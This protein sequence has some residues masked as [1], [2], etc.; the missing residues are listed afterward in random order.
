MIA[1]VPEPDDGPPSTLPNDVHA[2]QA[3][4]GAVMIDDRVL[5][6]LTRDGLKGADF[7]TPAH[8]TVW[9][10]MMAMQADGLPVDPVTLFHRVLA[11]GDLQRIGG[12]AYLHTL[13]ESTPT[14]ANAGY[15]ARIVRDLAVRRRII[16]AGTRITQL[17]YASDGSTVQDVVNAAQAETAGVADAVFGGVDR[18]GMDETIDTVLEAMESGGTPSLGTG[19]R[20]LDEALTGGLRGVVTVAGRPGTG[21]TVFG[22]E[23]A[24]RVAGRGLNVGVTTLERTPEDLTQVAIANLS[25]VAYSSI[26]QAPDP[27]LNEAQWRAVA[28]AA[29]TLRSRRVVF[30]QR[31]SA[32]TAEIAA[33]I[34]DMQRERG[35]CDLW[36]IDYLGLLTPADLRV[37]REQQISRMSRELKQLN[38][39]TGVPIL[40]LAQLNREGAKVGREPILTD[41]RDSGSI[42]Q[43]SDSVLLLHREEGPGTALH[44]IIPKNRR[45]PKNRLVL[46]FDGAYQTIGPATWVPGGGLQ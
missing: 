6:E 4:L 20:D 28:K 12:A 11:A 13:H 32:T 2:E 7:Y 31:P 22:V 17:G 46:N 38:R 29:E 27:P 39:S 40:L 25:R 15:Y 42:E 36:V 1:A 37:S 5:D 23:V 34:R 44:V 43:D 19:L 33:D 21:K 16:N 18:C 26:L 10:H 45:G 35:S 14:A 24:L 41:L 30:S 8:E 9:R 3:C